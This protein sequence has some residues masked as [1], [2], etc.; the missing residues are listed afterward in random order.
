M[1]A[2][3]MEEYEVAL[4]V[5]KT[6]QGADHAHKVAQVASA[7]WHY[8]EEDEDVYLVV[9][10]RWAAAMQDGETIVL[11]VRE[12]EGELEDWVHSKL[13]EW[14]ADE[15]VYIVERFYKDGRIAAA[16]QDGLP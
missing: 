6:E 15:D 10:V 14:E 11:S 16:G 3:T 2:Q 5:A 13:E 1:E 4:V 7:D 12:K 9:G 8:P